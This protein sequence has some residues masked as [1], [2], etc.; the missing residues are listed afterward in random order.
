MNHN[1]GTHSDE[2]QCIVGTWIVDAVHKTVDIRYG[3]V[4]VFEYWEYEVTC[5]DKDSN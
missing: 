5:F 4:D 1:D 3:L 2:E